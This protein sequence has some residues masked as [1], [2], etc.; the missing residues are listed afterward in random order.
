MS[1][2]GYYDDNG[3]YI[4]G[5]YDDNGNY[6]EGYYDE[7]GSYALAYYDEKGNYLGG[8]YYDERGEYV[9]YAYEAS[10]DSE[11]VYEIDDDDDLTYENLDDYAFK[12][13]NGYS[14]STSSSGKSAKELDSSM[15]N[16][17]SN[18]SRTSRADAPR[19]VREEMSGRTGK[20][21]KSKRL[22]VG[23][24]IGRFVIALLVFVLITV[25]GL[26]FT[27][28][29]ICK[30]PSE[31]AKNLFVS[32]IQETGQM[33]FLNKLFF[34]EEEIVAITGQNSMGTLDAELDTDL[35]TIG[36]S[37]EDGSGDSANDFDINGFELIEL[38][39]RTYY[40]KMM[41]IN[42]PSRVKLSTIYNG[43]WAEY[44]QCLDEFVENGNYLAGVNGGEYQ[45]DS[46]KGG[47]PKGIVV[48]DGEIQYN[49]PQAGDVL[50]GF[51]TDNILMIRDVGG[52]SAQQAKDLVEELQIRDCVTFKDIAD[53]DD[54]HFAKLIINGESIPLSGS[55]SGANPRTVIGQK[56]DGTVLILVTDGRGASGHLGATAADLVSIMQEYGAVNAA[57][58][59]GGSSSSMYY[60]GNYEMTSVT[61]YYANSS[62]RLP[63]AFVV[64]RRD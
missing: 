14:R 6:V 47:H 4:G 9:E 15:I 2:E 55:G 11:G 3:N 44:G 61:L 33:K 56:A 37:T 28:R 42:D 62:W 35:I 31:A 16:R 57:N 34:S 7:Y 12:G 39:G 18:S 29:T 38:T 53:G 17:R 23:K 41:I 10:D 5:F 50:I 30:G 60:D 13:S 20:R 63:L 26:Y 24:V 19:E 32:T 27:M 58:M 51:N 43:S 21:S 1:K 54:N 25:G 46:N 22:T 64:E 49:N 48:C 36:G 52:L 40:A 59:D 45:S 8:G